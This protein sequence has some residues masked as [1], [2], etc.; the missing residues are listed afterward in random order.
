VYGTCSAD[1]DV[2]VPPGV[3]LDLTTARG[4]L[5]L[6][7]PDT[8]TRLTTA[9]G[10]VH[11]TG[12]TT[13]RIDVSTAAG[14]VTVEFAAVP[15]DVVVRTAAGS[16]TIRVPDDGTAY[17][18]TGSTS[19]GSRRITVPVDIDSKHRIDVSSSVG[20]VTVTTR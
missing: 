10:S 5:E 20:S 18:V 14:G 2:T 4:T 1:L 15:D 6:D 11:V 16:V 8:Q 9:N 13:R 7:G 17:N 12:A 3:T 19:L